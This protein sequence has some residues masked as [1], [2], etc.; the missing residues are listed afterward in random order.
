MF[1]L[2][3]SWRNIWRNRRRTLITIASIFTAVTLVLFTRS[4]QFG[5]YDHIIGTTIRLYTSHLQIHTAGFW[6]SKSINDLL[7]DDRELISRIKQDENIELVT[8]RLESFALAAYRTSTRGV[9]VFGIVPESENKLSNLES[10]IIDGRYIKSDDDGIIVGDKLAEYLRI[11]IGD[12]LVLFSQGYHGVISAGKYPVVGIISLPDP[13]LNAQIVYMPLTMC[14]D[15]YNTGK[16]ITTL[17]ILLS[18]YRKSQ[19]VKKKLQML[20]GNDYEVLTWEEMMPEMVQYIKLDNA[21]GMLMLSILYVIVWFSILST[22]IMMAYERKKE[23]GIL[24]AIGTS[25]G[26]LLLILLMEMLW[27]TSLGVIFGEIF[28]LPILSYLRDNPIKLT[29]TAAEA[30]ARWGIDPVIAFSTR[31]SIF[32]AQAIVV[33]AM[34]LIAFIYPAYFVSRLKV[35]KALKQ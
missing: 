17:T 16:R 25:K 8:R 24:T 2:K 1:Y 30:M 6:E 29:G 35:V 23:F 27:I 26:R 4:M 5:T 7:R 32:I 19:D 13:K 22:L 34:S 14:Q 9:L 11:G 31:P 20:L 12:T 15:F 10:K 18:D 21:S 33:L 3:L 28:I